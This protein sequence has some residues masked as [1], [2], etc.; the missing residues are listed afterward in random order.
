MTRLM[1]PVLRSGARLWAARRIRRQR[2]GRSQR[3]TLRWLLYTARNTEYGLAWDFDGLL[4]QDDFYAAFRE[5]TPVT[6]YERWVAWLGDQSPVCEEGP[7]PLV[8]KAW[9]GRIDT[10]CLSSGTTSGRTKYVPYSPHMIAINRKAALDFFAHIVEAAPE[11]APPM[12]KTLYMSGSTDLHRNQSGSLS[13]DMSA[14][15]KFL[16]PKTLSRFAQPPQDVSALE[17]SQRL[18]ALVEICCRDSSVATLSGIPIWQVTLLEAIHERTGKLP[19]EIMPNLR[20]IIHGGMSIEPYKDKIQE[21]TCGRAQLYETYAASEI[22]IAAFQTPGEA[23]MR[24]CFNYDVFFEF[25]DEDGQT[26]DLSFVRPGAPYSLLVS[27]CAGL[28]R[29]RIGDVVVF[30]S[31]RPYILDYVTRDKTTSAFDEKLSEKQLE[32]AMAR[33]TPLISDFT[34][35]PDTEGRRHIWFLMTD[36]D[37]D[38]AWITDLDE[39]LRALHQDYDDYRGEER[40]KPPGIVRV[41]DRAAFLKKIGREEGGQRKFPRTLSPQE[42]AAL[43]AAYP[44]DVVARQSGK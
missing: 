36:L 14:L 8:D 42:T 4:R 11:V 7:Q 19:G 29:Y 17:W 43:L 28:W 41:A 40:I 23:G 3:E 27:T 20:A 26:G 30:R 35:G 18:D 5:R 44:V 38:Q 15:T 22:G 13:G 39:N 6:D 24:Y 21:L 31:V 9:P 16:A 1:T 2:R 10:F 32:L 34:L 37:L 25:E 12:S 33:M